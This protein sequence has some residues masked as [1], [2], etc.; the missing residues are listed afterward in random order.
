MPVIVQEKEILIFVAFTK[1]TRKDA[2]KLL[3]LSLL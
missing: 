1:K 3:F 2:C